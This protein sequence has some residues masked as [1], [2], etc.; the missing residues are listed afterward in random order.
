MRPVIFNTRNEMLEH[1]CSKL[2]DIK[3][4]EIGVFRGD[5]LSFL[6]N[7]SNI[8]S[9]DA[10]DLFQGNTFSGDQD[11]NNIVRCDVGKCYTD[12][13]EKYKQ[14]QKIKLH[15]SHS[16]LFLKNQPDNTYDIIYIDADHSYQG[17]KNDLIES[18][19]K[20]KNNGYIMGHDYEMNMNKAKQNFTFGVKQA[21]D[22]FCA[23]FNQIILAKAL[24]GCVGFCIQISK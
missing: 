3:A 4:L 23:E 15:K 5:F 17:T 22:E 13:V 12:L 11:G 6:Y 16:T 1:F 14:T 19:K 10:V 20:I 7:I 2:A 9:I 21:V 24:D 8:S 18:F